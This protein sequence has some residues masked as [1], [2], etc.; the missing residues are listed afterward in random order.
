MYPDVGF[1]T[2]TQEKEP[3]LL[4]KMANCR[5]GSRQYRMSLEHFVVPESKKVLKKNQTRTLN[6]DV[7]HVNGLKWP[8]ER[9]PN[10]Q[11]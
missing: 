7:K 6:S 9:A 1:S 2:I 5:A 3:G 4:G 8:N 11:S 10:S